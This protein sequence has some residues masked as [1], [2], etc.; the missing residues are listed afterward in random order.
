MIVNFKTINLDSFII[1]SD[2]LDHLPNNFQKFKWSIT[3]QKTLKRPVIISTNQSDIFYLSYDVDIVL[4]E[5]E[6]K[7]NI[8]LILLRIKIIHYYAI[9]TASCID[10]TLL[11]L[12]APDYFFPVFGKDQNFH[13]V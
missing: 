7:F 11:R 12:L 1:I 13:L 4:Y 2:Y 10:L 8:L 3:C 9:S 6:N 5:A